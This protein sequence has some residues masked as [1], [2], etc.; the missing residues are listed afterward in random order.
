MAEPVASASS[1]G[2]SGVSPTA[3]GATRLLSLLGVPDEGL[4][5]EVSAV[6]HAGCGDSGGLWDV[7]TGH[8]DCDVGWI[9]HAAGVAIWRL[10]NQRLDLYSDGRHMHTCG[11][12]SRMVSL[13]VFPISTKEVGQEAPKPMH[14]MSAPPCQSKLGGFIGCAQSIVALLP[15]LIGDLGRSAWK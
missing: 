12:A 9:A 10:Y 11:H 4:S 1:S 5:T 14:R 6:V 3:S 2:A 13:Q 7:S 8:R 15:A